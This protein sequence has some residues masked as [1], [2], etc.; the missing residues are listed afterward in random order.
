M[1]QT[2]TPI[3]SMMTHFRAGTYAN[4]YYKD[5]KNLFGKFLGNWKYESPTDVVEISIFKKV[6]YRMSNY[7]RDGIYM[8]VKYTKNGLVVFNSL[9]SNAADYMISGGSFRAPTNTNKYHMLYLEPN[10]VPGGAKCWVDISYFLSMGQPQLNWN[11]YYEPML[12]TAVPPIL[13]LQMTFIK[14][15]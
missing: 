3:E 6:N 11:M 7:Y 14:M 8:R 4:R 12:D 5:V 15:P 9:N 1:A 2:V 13:P 10:M